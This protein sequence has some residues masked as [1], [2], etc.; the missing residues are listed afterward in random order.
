MSTQNFWS[1]RKAQVEAEEIAHVE[2]AEATRRE[3]MQVEQAE[4]SDEELLEELGLPDPDGLKDGDDF[5]GFM[6]QAVPERLRRRAL[7]VLWRSNPVFANVDGLVDYGEDF[8]D[9]ATVIENLQTTYQVGKG[10]QKHVEEMDRQAAEAAVAAEAEEAEADAVA[11][12]AVGEDAQ[13]VALAD[14]QTGIKETAYEAPAGVLD[15]DPDDTAPVA[16]ARMRFRFDVS[17]EVA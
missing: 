3:A 17:E 2:A 4:K 8:T 16:V 14:A 6:G 1:R 12:E 10:L 9:A 13:D 11:G 7:R 15:D 5:T